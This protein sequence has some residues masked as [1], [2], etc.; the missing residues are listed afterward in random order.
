MLTFPPVRQSE[1]QNFVQ[2]FQDAQKSNQEL[3]EKQE[4]LLKQLQE[5]IDS[6]KIENEKAQRRIAVLESSS[7][8]AEGIE[9]ELRETKTPI[10]Y[11]NCVFE[12]FISL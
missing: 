11:L 5:E 1:Y 9:E 3:I 2:K 8:Q 12:S 6:L 7:N 4:G 10:I